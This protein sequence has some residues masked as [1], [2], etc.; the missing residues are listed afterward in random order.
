MLVV[1]VVVVVVGDV[2]FC[3]PPLPHWDQGLKQKIFY[4]S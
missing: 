4:C 2:K 3:L 1:V